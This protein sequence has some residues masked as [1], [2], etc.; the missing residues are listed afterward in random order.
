[1][2]TE[3]VADL[4]MGAAAVDG[5]GDL[6]AVALALEASVAV[7]VVAAARGECLDP[8]AQAESIR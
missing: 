7:E 1:M 5:V 3:W 8:Q 2:Q 4:R 6:R